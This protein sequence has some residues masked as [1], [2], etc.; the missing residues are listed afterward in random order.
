[1]ETKK[2]A[3]FSFITGNPSKLKNRFY[4]ILLHKKPRLKR[5]LNEVLWIYMIL[6]GTKRNFHFY[7]K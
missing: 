4:W 2:L 3:A 7:Q 6:S 1:M 5:V